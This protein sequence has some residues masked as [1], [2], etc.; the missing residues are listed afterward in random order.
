MGRH[1]QALRL[2]MMALFASPADEAPATATFCRSS[3]LKRLAD[4]ELTVAC[5]SSNHRQ[6]LQPIA[7]SGYVT[8]ITSCSLMIKITDSL[9]TPGHLISRHKDDLAQAHF[10]SCQA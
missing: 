2:E 8:H 1:Y 3:P 5:G 7:L 10:D 6:A 4:G 9:L